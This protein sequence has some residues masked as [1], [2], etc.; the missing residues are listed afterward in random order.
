MTAVVLVVAKAPVP[1]EAKTRLART[2][3]DGVAADI[4][5]AALLDTLSAAEGT[6][7][8]VVVAWSGDMAY[9]ARRREVEAAL[10]RCAVISQRGRGLAERLVNAHRDASSEVGRPVVQIGMDTP[11]VTAAQLRAAAGELGGHDAALGMA[12]DGGWWLLGSR[13][14]VYVEGLGEVAMSREDTGECTLA[15]LAE[16]GAEVALLEALRDV[17]TAPDAWSVAGHPTCGPRFIAAMAACRS[18]SNRRSG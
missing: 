2:V 4:A 13:S 14:P 8:S 15:A 7:L 6:G 17:D 11:Q 9:A 5:A 3:G 16:V 18:T 10:R 1:G 12:A